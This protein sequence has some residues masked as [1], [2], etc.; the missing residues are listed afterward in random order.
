VAGGTET[1]AGL[2]Y[3][4]SGDTALSLVPGS[5]PTDIGPL[6]AFP[7]DDEVLA[8]LGEDP[9]IPGAIRLGRFSTVGKVAEYT[10]IPPEPVQEFTLGIAP[11]G[12][13]Y[14]QASE[15]ANYFVGPVKRWLLR[16]DLD[17]GTTEVVFRH[18][19]MG[20]CPFDSFGVD[21][22]GD[23][24]WVLNPDFVVY[25]VEPAGAAE[26]FASQT[27]VDA[28]YVNQN[29]K[30][31]V[32]LNSPEGLYRVWQATLAERLALVN[33]AVDDLVTFGA[34]S[35]GRGRSL[36][37]KLH[38]AATTA[39]RENHRA[40]EAQVDAFLRSLSR[41]VV[42]GHLDE[43][44]ADHVVEVMATLGLSASLG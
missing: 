35:S 9:V 41:F 12:T 16:L 17:T 38:A 7:S 6:A 32:F 30:G 21:T 28:G 11:D 4:A 20:C 5:G 40:A 23:L 44:P 37:A 36:S 25:H 19:R 3:A 2:Y 22:A 39:E 24:W 27:P 18:D 43:K 34:L 15:A 1:F 31:D 10:I 42:T 26:L 14:A 13:V 33:E 8:H 29:S